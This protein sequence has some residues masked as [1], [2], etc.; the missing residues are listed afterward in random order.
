MIRNYFK[1]ALR[2]LVKTK[3]FSI[4]NITG[5]TVGITAFLLIAL[6]I[7]DELTFDRFHKNASHIYRV[8]DNRI[9]EVGKK[10]KIAGAGYQVSE[11]G[12][13]DLPEIKDVARMAVFGRINVMATENNNVFYED[14]TFGSP[15]FLTVF[16]FPLLQGDRNSALTLPHSV[17]VTEETAR[18]LFGTTQVQGKTLQ[19]GKDTLLYKITGVLKDFPVN[20]STSFHLIFSESSITSDNFKKFISNDWTSDN[21]STF[22]LLNEKAN[23]RATESKLN[24]LVA[25]NYKSN[26][27]EKSILMLQPLT[28]M[29][30]Y[31]GD[32]E[33]YTSG[34]GSLTYIYVF[35]IVGF[36]VL[37]IAC[38]N[39]MNLATARFTGRAKEIGIR[40]VAGASRE[41]LVA[42]FLSEAYLVALLAIIFSIILA[43]LLLPAFNSFTGKQLMLGMETDYRVWI[44]IILLVIVVSLLS[45]LYPAL[46]Q[47]GL[48][49]LSLLKNKLKPGRW[50]ISLRRSLVVFQ[51]TLS[52]IMIIA[53]VVVF[54]QMNYISNR[55]LGF[56]KDQLVVVD[57][58]SGKIRHDAET[59]INEFAKLS[60]VID[61]TVSSRVPGEWKNLPMVKV[62]K[63]SAGPPD[64]NDMFFLGV[65]EHFLK[66][67]DIKLIK[68]R[69][70]LTGSTA[71][72][73]AVLINESAARELGIVE[74][75]GQMITI[76]A[77]NFG[78]DFSP[79]DQPF[80]VTV[81]GIVKD[82]NFQSL[83]E[84]L[85]PMILGWQKNPVQSID[86]FTA[87]LA[88]GGDMA[89][90]LK[91]M[92]VILHSV[93]QSHLFEYHF[94]DRQWDLFYREDKIRQTIFLILAIL[95][96][97][98]AC[99]GLF[100]LATYAAE[101][102]VKEIG[103]RKVLGATVKSIVVMLS[104][105]FLKL[106]LIASVIAFPVGWLSMNKWL[107]DFAYRI[108]ISRWVFILSALAA[109]VIAL[110]TIS[111]QAIKAGLAN[112]VKA[113]RSE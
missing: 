29:H 35:F 20:S 53:T 97:F 33:G 61:I 18:K 17:I 66:T 57:I 55:D 62:K 77:A 112:P 113:L 58:N 78:G 34:K 8:V 68:G 79:L 69:N 37:F 2:S 70:F 107:Q 89:A 67:Y 95:A 45:G 49:P 19:A 91:Q 80:V 63:E 56:K 32:I 100:G 51:F 111:F 50:N 16:D 101:Q 27:A 54:L 43:K 88:P 13:K 98:I 7:F 74:P 64:G 48:R 110:V 9:S 30:F 86:Y 41:N 22:L 36:F 94:L 10:T 75:A 105:D 81:A 5:L 28:D 26:T 84:P 73:S 104:K 46:F 3:V 109:I 39:Y 40:K 71:D 85:A 106:V 99:L 14:F 76:P 4:I 23:S 83:H 31:S 47:S 87:R 92:D 44:G 59:I 96:V 52:I 102:R 21:F 103:I 6:Y 60:P 93:D 38:I 24:H 1:I 90:T 12:K 108:N 65:D 72:S 11:K 42:Q 15:G 25:A 82:F